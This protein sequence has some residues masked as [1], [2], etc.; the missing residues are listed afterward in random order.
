[1]GRSAY[2][3]QVCCVTQNPLVRRWMASKRLCK[4]ASLGRWRGLRAGGHFRISLFAEDAGCWRLQIPAIAHE[5]FGSLSDSPC[6]QDAR[7]SARRASHLMIL[8]GCVL[9]PRDEERHYGG[10]LSVPHLSGKCL[11]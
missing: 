6:F 9:Q 4:Q 11:L 7:R 10:S 2:F 1:M 5:L 8:I 3:T